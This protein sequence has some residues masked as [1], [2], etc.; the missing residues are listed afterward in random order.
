MNRAQLYKTVGAMLL[1]SFLV[2][3]LTAII[4]VLRIKVPHTQLVFEIHEYNGML[5][6]VVA[7]MHVV[8]NWGWLKANF[9]KKR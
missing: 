5:M 2:Q 1:L 9:F 3:A 4:I 8:L 7:A 6:I